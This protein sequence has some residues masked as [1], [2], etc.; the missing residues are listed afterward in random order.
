MQRLLPPGMTSLSS[1]A[2]AATPLP[3]LLPLLPPLLLLPLLSVLLLLTPAALLLLP[4]Q[5]L[6]FLLVMVPLLRVPL[7]SQ[8]RQT[9]LEV[10]CRTHADELGALLRT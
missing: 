7:V 1:C 10:S 8:Q 4:L 3:L 6:R 2:G 9:A 5:L